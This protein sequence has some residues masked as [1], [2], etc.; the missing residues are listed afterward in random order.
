MFV[1]LPFYDLGQGVG[2]NQPNHPM[3]VKLFLYLS[4]QI[5]RMQRTAN[6]VLKSK[7]MPPLAATGPEGQ[8]WLEWLYSFC[9]FHGFN[10]PIPASE[11][12]S[13]QPQHSDSASLMVML[14][15]LF[16]KH[17]PEEF[18][19]P[20]FPTASGVNVTASDLAWHMCHPECQRSRWFDLPKPGAG[21]QFEL[22]FFDISSITTLATGP[23]GPWTTDYTLLTRL[24]KQVNACDWSLGLPDPPQ[25]A[26]YLAGAFHLFREKVR[27]LGWPVE[28]PNCLTVNPAAG[29]L[30]AA[31]LI[32]PM[33]YVIRLNQQH[34]I[35]PWHYPF[36]TV[37]SNDPGLASVL[38]SCPKKSHI[39]S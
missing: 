6:F 36:G 21:P 38:K 7:P 32:R 12:M 24:L 1:W 26:T 3:D 22:P 16:Y 14:N 39:F 23:Q 37:L 11:Q 18:V 19:T 27:T 15:K 28:T 17:F 35:G 2:L 4:E 25:N 13:V 30:A 31:S 9:K 33:N 8:K 10:G 34:P 5:R 29:N 20:K